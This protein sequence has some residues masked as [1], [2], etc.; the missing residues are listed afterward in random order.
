VRHPYVEAGIDKAGVRTLARALGLG[1]VAE[2]PAS[3]CLS[4]RIET[5]IAIDPAELALVHAVEI[6]LA[7]ILDVKT[8]RC[9]VRR[10][11]LVVELDAADL[12]ALT[13]ARRE[14]ALAEVATI[15]RERGRPRP[16][17]LA[18]YRMGSAFLRPHGDG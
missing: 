8:V 15:A 3:P 16:V 7:R 6:R 17:S 12:D 14:A 9:R 5:G 2:L 11:G 4:S 1:D 18:P 13:A 10:A